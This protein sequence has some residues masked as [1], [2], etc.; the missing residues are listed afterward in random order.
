M[1]IS[2]GK[3]FQQSLA[4]SASKIS[5]LLLSLII[6]LEYMTLVLVG[7]KC[8]C[9]QAVTNLSLLNEIN[10]SLNKPIINKSNHLGKQL[11]KQHPPKHTHTHTQTKE[12]ENK[13]KPP[14]KQETK[15]KKIINQNNKNKKEGK[16]RKTKNHLQATDPC[17]Y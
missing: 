4:H 5:E 8:L 1:E 9:K 14:S 6:M 11:T 3:R 7:A 16:K 17:S 10:Q 13:N 15:N 2:E 12:D